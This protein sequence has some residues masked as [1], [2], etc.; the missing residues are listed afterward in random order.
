MTK[1]QHNDRNGLAL[2]WMVIGVLA[3]LIPHPAN[4]TPMA[5]ISLF[6]GTHLSKAK[7]FSLG[8]ATMVISDILIAYFQGNPVFGL[9]SFFTYSG[10]AAIIFAGSFLRNNPSAGRTLGYLL[11]SSLGFWIWT[12]FGVWATGEH[13]LY[14]HTFEGLVSC[15]VSALPFLRNALVGD[16]GFGLVFFLSFSYARK[17]AAQYGYTVQGA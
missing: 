9:W 13:Q 11:G 5:S 10:F 15:Y 12:N 14:A 6:G 3:R 7:A 16:L 17:T 1:T 2:F 8:F 4:M